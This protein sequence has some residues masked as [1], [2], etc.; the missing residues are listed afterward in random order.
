MRNFL[1]LVLLL[2]MN[3]ANA[4]PTRA[5]V[6]TEEQERSALCAIEELPNTVHQ[7]L[8]DASLRFLSDQDRI[9]ISEAYQVDD[10]PR[11]LTR[12]YPVHAAITLGK[13][14]SERE[15]AH[16]YD[17]SERF[18]RF[19]LLLEVAKKSGRLTPK[20]IGKAKEANFESMR[21]INLELY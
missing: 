12:C 11:S 4:L 13:S 9:A 1:L 3:Q 2:F 19:H 6:A 18:M 17:L 5:Y 7:N 21:K 10:V 14:Y 8:L 15:F 20:Q 16:F